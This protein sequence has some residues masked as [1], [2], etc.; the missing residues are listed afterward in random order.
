MPVEDMILPVSIIGVGS[1]GRVGEPVSVAPVYV[2][3]VAV[4]VIPVLVLIVPLPSPITHPVALCIVQDLV[5]Q[6]PGVTIE[7]L[8][9]GESI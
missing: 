9:S 1:L 5:F 3:P 4:F 6:V 8:S 7:Q 2:T